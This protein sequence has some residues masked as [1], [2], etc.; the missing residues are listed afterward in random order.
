MLFKATLASAAI[1]TLA[2]AQG[3]GVCNAGDLGLYSATTNSTSLCCPNPIINGTNF[4]GAYMVGSNVMVN[5]FRKFYLSNVR[6][7]T[8]YLRVC[9]F[10]VFFLKK[11]AKMLHPTF[12]SDSTFQLELLTLTLV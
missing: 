10:C 12:L 8:F 1:I 7:V 6:N 9:F 11:S 5:C 3:S 4:C 2:S